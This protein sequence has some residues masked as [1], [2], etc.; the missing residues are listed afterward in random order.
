ML[1]TRHPSLR[2]IGIDFTDKR[3]HAVG[4]VHLRT[5][6][7]EFIFCLY[8]AVLYVDGTTCD[9]CVAIINRL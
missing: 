4:I 2:K 3:G 9:F 5:Q 8:V 6:A 7:T 1:T